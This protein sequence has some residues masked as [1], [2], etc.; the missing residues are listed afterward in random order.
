MRNK[1]SSFRR[2]MEEMWTIMFVPYV[3]GVHGARSSAPH[4]A[5]AF[6]WMAWH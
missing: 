2:S 3:D 5:F 6:C 1:R 4:A